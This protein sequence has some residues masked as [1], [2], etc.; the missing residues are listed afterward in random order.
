MELFVFSVP[1]VLTMIR[2]QEC[3]GKSMMNV[4]LGIWRMDSVSHV[5]LVMVMPQQTEKPSMESAPF[6]IVQDHMIKTVRFL[7]R[8]TN[9][10]SVS[11]VST[12]THRCA[13]WPYPQAVWLSKTQPV[14]HVKW[15]I[16]W[17]THQT[18]SHYHPTAQ[19]PMTQET[20]PHAK[21]ASTSTQKSTNVS[22]FQPTVRPRIFMETVP[23]VIQDCLSTRWESA[24]SCQITVIERLRTTSVRCAMKGTLLTPMGSVGFWLQ[25]VLRLA[26]KVNVLNA[27]LASSLIWETNAAFFPWIVQ[28]LT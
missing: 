19:S 11:K 27:T 26:H 4:R 12:Q 5:S 28:E 10:K 16:T 13:A 20:V 3:V 2:F 21:Q 24:E 23:P 25:I 17:R 1:S 6:T 22:S 9:A 8:R 15:T 7:W 14:Q 18:V